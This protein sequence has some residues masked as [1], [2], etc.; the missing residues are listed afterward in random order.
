MAKRDCTGEIT[1]CGM[2]ECYT[3]YIDFP[4]RCAFVDANRNYSSG[5][6]AR[7]AAKR[8]AARVGI[9]IKRLPG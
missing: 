6:A 5:T 9:C 3:W 4:G 2:D 7:R 1:V 8:F